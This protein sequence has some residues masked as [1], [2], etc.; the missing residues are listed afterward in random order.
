MYCTERVFICV[1]VLDN[2]L[3]T[4]SLKLR[5]HVVTSPAPGVV[6]DSAQD[7]DSGSPSPP[8]NT[9]LLNGHAEPILTRSLLQVAH[10][11]AARCA[12]GATVIGRQLVV[13]GECTSGLYFRFLSSKMLN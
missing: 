1:A 10:M 12:I 5:N 2:R 4:M 6:V 3:L 13:L 11:S 8:I 9:S 7:V